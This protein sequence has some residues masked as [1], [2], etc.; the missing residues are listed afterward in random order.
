MAEEPDIPEEPIH[1]G[2]PADEIMQTSSIPAP[3]IQPP[4]MEVHHHPD[5]HHRR[6]KFREYFLEFI[7]IFLAVTLGFI[8]ENIREDLAD[9]IKAKEYGQS[10]YD[11]L[12]ADSSGLNFNIGFNRWR[13]TKIDSFILLLTSQDIQQHGQSLYYYQAAMNLQ[14]GFTPVDITAQQLRNSG[15]LRFF[16]NPEI[17]NLIASYYSWV[18]F[19]AARANERR[20]V[21]PNS[22]TSKLFY[23]DILI[24]IGM[25]TA[26]IKN[27]IRMPEAGTK[28][29]STD[30]QA[31]NEYL[32]YA[33]DFK[34]ANELS[35]YFL[36]GIVKEKLY[37]LMGVLRK[38]YA[39]R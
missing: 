29:L 7:M 10:L 21:I 11:D 4:D 18:N 35:Y 1:E 8:A 17:Y 25:I 33:G 36:N 23:A 38:E 24:S 19:Y 3:A 6:K 31:L 12:K 34:S 28:L 37:A 14:I 2:A 30:K 27:S 5:L 9:R 20:V 15:G 13:A 32:L 22:L 26:D 16:K 39:V